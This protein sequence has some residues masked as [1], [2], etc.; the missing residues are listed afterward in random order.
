MHRNMYRAVR[1]PQGVTAFLI[2]LSLLL[3]ALPISTT[4]AYGEESASIELLEYAG[5]P[6][7]EPTDW[8]VTSGDFDY[9]IEH[10]IITGYDNGKYGPYDDITRGQVAT[11]LWRIAEEPLAESKAFDDVNYNEYYGPAIRWA[12]AEG[13]INGYTGTNDF[14]P[15]APVTREQLAAMLSNYV[16]KIGGLDVSSDLTA[17]EAIDGA[18]EVSDWALSAMGWAVDNGIISGDLSSGAARVNPQGTA[19][20]CMAVKMM[21]VLHRDILGLGDAPSPEDPQEPNEPDTPDNPNEPAPDGMDYNDDA[22]VIDEDEYLPTGESSALIDADIAADIEEGDVIIL[23]PTDD[24]PSGDAIKVKSL[25]PSGENVSVSGTQPEFSEVFDAL[26]ISGSTSTVIE[27]ELEPGVE[28]V[29]EEGEVST[30]ATVDDKFE[31]VD[32]T[33]KIGNYGTVDL[34][35]SVNYRVDYFLLF[36][37][38]LEVSIN[39]KAKFNWD[40]ET[41]IDKTIKIGKATFVTS[42]PGVTIDAVFSVVAA[43]DGE[44]H[45]AVTASA[46]AGISYDHGEWDTEFKRSLDYEASFGGHVKLGVE[47]SVAIDV[48]S[49]PVVDAAAEVSGNIDGELNQRRADFV[50]CDLSAWIYVGISVGEGDS[51]ANDLG[52]SKTFDL[53]TKKNSP[54]WTLHAENGAI[55]SECTW[56]NQPAEP[57]DSGDPDNPGGSDNPD[58][59]LTPN[60]ASHFRYTITDG[61]WG[62]GVYIDGYVGDSSSVIVPQTIEDANVVS[63]Y[64]DELSADFSTI[65]L[66]AAKQLKNVALSA[67]EASIKFGNLEQLESINV[68][69]GTNIVG[70]FDCYQCSNVKSIAFDNASSAGPIN[71]GGKLHFNSQNLESLYI[72]GTNLAGELAID[73]APKLKNA[74]IIDTF[75]KR[76]D[77]GYC[78]ELF[79]LIV[80]NTMI[81]D[82]DVSQYQKLE[83]LEC[84]GNQIEDLS[85]LENWLNQPGHSGIVSHENPYDA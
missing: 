43:A 51:L 23:S 27:F 47:P 7:V 57:G 14:G 5:Y 32:K 71:L 83:Y 12:R 74:T 65:D 64:I 44:A 67:L 28:M 60:P 1:P 20:R 59:E 37:N 56:N 22:I 10:G 53:V 75:I 35:S 33:F 54:K 16:S 25:T 36:M 69:S 49:L 48:L 9:S 24:Y 80:I 50:C 30:L 55:V 52:L 18:D 8:Y 68:L 45:L 6:D 41:H 34:T 77:L 58:T 26:S 2:A 21:S 70:D 11:I 63:L 62:Y 82:L 79:S 19:Q 39:A 38:E 84:W 13:V 46:T 15:D 76:I 61:E 3:A 73:A 81:T 42:V 72:S 85:T 4:V 29:D 66:S 78:P 17:L 31:L 40:Y